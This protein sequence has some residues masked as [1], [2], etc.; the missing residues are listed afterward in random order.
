METNNPENI[1]RGKL[2]G[3]VGCRYE[4]KSLKAHTDNVHFYQQWLTEQLIK[5]Q[6]A[7]YM[8]KELE[9]KLKLFG[10]L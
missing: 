6:T 8:M 4:C 3:V 1:P 2:C 9:E 5:K 7:E 10:L